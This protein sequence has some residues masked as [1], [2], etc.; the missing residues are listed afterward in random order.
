[1]QIYVNK[2]GQ[3]LGPFDEAKLAEMLRFGQILPHD[4]AIKPGD[5]NWSAVSKLLASIN[6]TANTASLPSA[7]EFNNLQVMKW[8]EQNLSSPLQAQ[9]K[10][11]SA[12]GKIGGTIGLFIIPEIFLLIGLIFSVQWMLGQTLVNPIL[13]FTA[14]FFSAIP[15]LI[16][17]LTVHFQRK[18]LVAFLD[19]EGVEK[20]NGDRQ[21]WKD[22]YQ[23][24]Y[25]QTRNARVVGNPLA[26]LLAS[27]IVEIMFAGNDR[28]Q[29][30]LVFAN[31]KVTIPP[32]ISNQSEIVTL[33]ETIPATVIGR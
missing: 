25:S 10:F 12:F 7:A 13:F 1:M 32:L 22:L 4:Y 28:T 11:D 9:H 21:S 17:W 19:C 14:A 26:M 27:I 30:E 6:P 16:I 5:K 8:A 3:Q 29:I 23:V 31:G 2:N 33:F 15:F 24:N 18:K 20:R